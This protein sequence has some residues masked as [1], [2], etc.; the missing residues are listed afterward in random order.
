VQDGR[1]LIKRY[2]LLS[3]LDETNAVQVHVI[4]CILLYESILSIEKGTL[5][6][7]SG[8]M[9]YGLPIIYAAPSRKG[10]KW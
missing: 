1:R 6:I 9:S 10:R 3:H 8:E 7:H 4:I 5:L 2:T